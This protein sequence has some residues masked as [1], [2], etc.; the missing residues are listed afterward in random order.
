MINWINLSLKCY[1]SRW[2]ER[3]GDVKYYLCPVWNFAD[4]VFLLSRDEKKSRKRKTHKNILETRS[5]FHFSLIL[6]STVKRSWTHL[7]S[8]CGV[9]RVKNWKFSFHSVEINFVW[10]NLI[11]FLCF[12]GTTVLGNP[13]KVEQI[14]DT[15][16]PY[17]VFKD[18]LRGLAESS[19]RY[20]KKK[21][22]RKRE[23]LWKW[24]WKYWKRG[25]LIGKF[26]FRFQRIKL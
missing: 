4:V 3:D 19:F 22:T 7:L 5:L 20:E 2:S 13:T 26:L 10:R 15:F 14:G 21:K 1:K 17:Q 25:K 24:E 16:I 9:S 11:A 6:N 18:Y 23:K 8:S 12:Q